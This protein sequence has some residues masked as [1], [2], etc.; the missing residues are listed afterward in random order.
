MTWRLYYREDNTGGYNLRDSGT[1]SGGSLTRTIT[2]LDASTTY[3][4]YLDVEYQADTSIDDTSLVGSYTTSASVS[5]G[6]I[7]VGDYEIALSSI[8]GGPSTGGYDVGIS[9][10]GTLNACSSSGMTQYATN[11]GS[12]HTFTGVN[13]GNYYVYVCKDGD[14]AKY[15]PYT[16]ESL[17]I[18]ASISTP[19]GTGEVQ[20]TNISGG[21]SDGTNYYIGI[22]TSAS[23][24]YANATQELLNGATSYTFDDSDNNLNDGQTYYVM[25]RK[26]TDTLSAVALQTG[27]VSRTADIPDI[28]NVDY[29]PGTVYFDVKNNDHETA[30]IYWEVI[31]TNSG[32]TEDFGTLEGLA[33]GT[34][35]AAIYATNI[36]SNKN[37]RIKAKATVN[38]GSYYSE[39]DI[40]N[41]TNSISLPTCSVNAHNQ[42]T[43]S[44]DIDY[45]V[46]SS[47]GFDMDWEL[48][49]RES[50]G[51]WNPLDS[52]TNDSSTG[53]L[54]TTVSGLS[55]NTDYDVRISVEYSGDSSLNTSASD[56]IRTNAA[57]PQLVVSTPSAS[58]INNN[59]EVELTSSFSGG[60]GTYDRAAVGTSESNA[61]GNLSIPGEYVS[62][63]G[64]SETFT[65]TDNGT[66]FVAVRDSQPVDAVSSGRSVASIK[67][68]KPTI[69]ITNLTDTSVTYQVTNND[70]EDGRSYS[71]IKTS[72]GSTV[73]AK[74]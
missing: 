10:N 33:A 8:A 32:T 20:V 51:G 56:S 63:P 60:S 64:S 21:P 30:D 47:Q 1:G 59:R 2:G 19:G 72:G 34:E 65:V 55:D 9:T 50:G 42:D 52:G 23:N 17:L 58:Y 66:Y 46:T 35:S 15:G 38:S 53:T 28:R 39:D 29:Y 12:S 48:E 37:I 13:P 43:N 41:T 71:I 36:S 40:F 68:S 44:F 6:T 45:S 24:P 49:Y 4:V 27:A 31:N 14:T 5:I 67:Y 7:T 26:G 16:V 3:Q 73:W 11:V 74:G 62:S 22:E 61:A 57:I 25:L 69:A 54:S 18:T 70:F